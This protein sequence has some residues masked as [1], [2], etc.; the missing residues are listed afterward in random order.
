MF[1]KSLHI[2]ILNIKLLI[3]KQKQNKQKI[4]NVQQQKWHKEMI[5]YLHGRI[6]YSY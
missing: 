5:V 3:E 2:K 4:G 6:L 1:E